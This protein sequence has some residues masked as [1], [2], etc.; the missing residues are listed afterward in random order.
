M[1]AG[2]QFKN[3]MKKETKIF[4]W[5][6]GKER[7]QKSAKWIN[8]YNP[9]NGKVLY[10]VIN[11]TKNDVNQAIT[12][13]HKNYQS[14]SRMPSPDRGKIIERIGL[15]MSQNEKHLSNIFAIETGKPFK[16][17]MGELHGAIKQANFFAGE[18]VRL[19]G[20][21]LR[22]SI[23]N[24]HSYTIRESLGVAGLI[25]PANTPIANIAWKVFP[26][27][28]CG[29]TIVLKASE[30]A[31]RIAMEFAKICKEAGLPDGVLNIIH[32][33]GSQ[34][35]EA[36]V[37]DT[38]VPVIS[39]TGST[40]VGKRIASLA[41]SRLA[42]VSLELGGI[43]PFVVCSDADLDLAVEWAAL[44]AFSNAGQR[45][46]AASRLIIFEDIYSKFKKKL[47][48]KTKNLKLG[49]THSSDLGPLINKKQQAAAINYFED[50]RKKNG[51]I[52]CGG[53]E[54]NYSKNLNGYYIQPT[55]IENINIESELSNTEVF[56]PVALMYKAKDLDHAIALSNSSEY[57]LTGAIH[58]SSLDN[59]MRFA[60][61]L[62]SGVVNI[63]LG[64]YGSEPH[65]PFGG[66]GLSGNGTREPGV[67]ALDIYSELK[68]ISYTVSK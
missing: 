27:L 5:L 30:D 60:H 42:K 28:I 37:L 59:A 55:L 15:L 3:Y 18:G 36:L 54:G 31:P 46:A 44:S 50:V 34:A 4:N 17:A 20:K 10:Q 63:N 49:V 21:S 14:W 64:T 8:K 57:G 29:N 7:V 67:E 40:A 47:L 24:K 41:G 35:G 68:N 26:A 6:G 45:C 25:V 58:S 39:F 65:M 9:H 12:I 16:D 52:I 53:K 48:L 43:N 22:S 2:Q 66:F 32:G 38:R 56:A 51:K 23:P 13:A 61:S 62:R 11:S 33:L 19:Y 1:A